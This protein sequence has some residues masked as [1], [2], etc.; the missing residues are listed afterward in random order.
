M[1]LQKFLLPAVIKPLTIVINQS[2]ATGIFPE[3]LK[4]AKVMPFYKN[5]DITLMD[6][7]RPV[8]LFTSISKV[9]EKVV[10][11][12]LYEFFDKHNLFFS[13]QYGFR[14]KHSTEMAGLEL[15]D[16]ILKDIDNKDISLAIFMDLSKAFD[17]LDH[18]ILL[19]KLKY[20]GVNDISLKWFSSYLTGRQ[21]Y[22]EIDGYS[23]G[24]LP[25]TTGVPQGSILGPLLFLIYMNDIPHATDYFDFISY[26]DDTSLFSKIQAPVTSPI[27]INC[28]RHCR[29]FIIVFEMNKWVVCLLF[30]ALVSYPGFW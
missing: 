15:T 5:D 25:L 14:K 22:V 27:D 28:C 12:Q 6:N 16:K 2:L 4:I 13:S 24:L 18:Q 21:Q 23:S 26:E 9:F 11:T 17:T 7:Y 10:F 8:S 29:Q 30:K 20:C 1:K 3:K 19:N